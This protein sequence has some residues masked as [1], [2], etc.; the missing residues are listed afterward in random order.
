MV[1]IPRLQAWM[2]FDIILGEF[3]LREHR[4]V[5]DY[6]DNRLWQKGLDSQQSP[7][8]FDLPKVPMP[9]PNISKESVLPKWLATWN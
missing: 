5:L 3:W 8:S 1:R 9:P 6:A 7:M 4:G 2:C